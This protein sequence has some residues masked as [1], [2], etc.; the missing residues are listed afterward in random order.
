MSEQTNSINTE[1]PGGLASSEPLGGPAASGC[2]VLT[3]AITG[4]KIPPFLGE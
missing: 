4:P 1:K 2:C 3:G